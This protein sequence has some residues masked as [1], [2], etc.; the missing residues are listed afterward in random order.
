MPTGSS[1]LPAPEMAKSP[2]RGYCKNQA[3]VVRQSAAY[4]RCHRT[5]R[6][7]TKLCSFVLVNVISYF[8]IHLVVTTRLVSCCLDP[9]RGGTSPRR[10]SAARER[11]RRFAE[12]ICFLRREERRL[13][14]SPTVRGG[15]TE[16][17][18]LPGAKFKRRLLL[19]LLLAAAAASVGWFPE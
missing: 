2:P 1:V 18:T 19:L 4:E 16:H 12:Y 15:D 11:A 8:A 10:P 17:R 6:A 5:T 9:H 13:P 3:S 14:L 7:V